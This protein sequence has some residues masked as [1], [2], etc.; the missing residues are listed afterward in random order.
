MSSCRRNVL[1][2][3]T[4]ADVDESAK[5]CI[6]LG[7]KIIDGPKP[8]GEQHFCVIQDPAG[9]AVALVSSK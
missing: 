5:R 2:Y 4:V 8:M 7:G 3:I 9:A 1:I 6:E